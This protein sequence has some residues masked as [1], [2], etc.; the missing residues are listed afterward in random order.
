MGQLGSKR[1][2]VIGGGCDTARSGM[3]TPRQVEDYN[4]GTAS[5]EV[6]RTVLP[7]RGQ[8]TVVQDTETE[9]CASRDAPGAKFFTP[10]EPAASHS[11]T[12]LL[13]RT[14]S[15][16]REKKGNPSAGTT[17]PRTSR[18]TERPSCDAQLLCAFPDLGD[19]QPPGDVMRFPSSGSNEIIRRMKANTFHHFPTRPLTG[20]QSA[21]AAVKHF[22]PWGPI[23]SRLRPTSPSVETF[24]TCSTMRSSTL[25]APALS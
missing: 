18:T 11:L 15:W 1:L 23:C 21:S 16:S 14:A 13:P 24:N 4:P 25:P 5:E 3:K 7:V 9:S 6:P 2:A 20:E 12:C 19:H 17:G 10:H 22:T 8:S